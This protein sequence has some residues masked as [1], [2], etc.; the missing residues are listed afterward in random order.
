M[1]MRD[2][3]PPRGPRGP[4]GSGEDI[5]G[6]RYDR[7]PPPPPRYPP[8][9]GSAPS[10]RPDNPYRPFG[11]SASSRLPVPY[12]RAT[13]GTFNRL[14]ASGQ[15]YAADAAEDVEPHRRRL[16]FAIF[17][18]GNPGHLWRGS[19]ASTLGEGTLGVG[20][21]IW[22]AALTVSPLDVALGVL[23]LGLPFVLAGPLAARF[24]SSPEPGVPLRW[25]NRLRVLL[26]LGFIAMHFHT[27]LPVVY[28][29]L[30]AVSLC[31]RLHDALR[32]A[33]VRTCLARG[34]PEHVAN[35]LYI[36]SALAAVLG[37]L[38]ATFC[39]ILLGE[40]ILLIA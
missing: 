14:P 31:G 30:F 12:Q 4:R 25:L 27:I 8:S 21:L 40:R 17:H 13:L 38:V 9:R 5:P 15:A 26:A 39:Y 19:V 24:E 18:D 7:T 20:V 32:V 35:D 22:L 28:L 34:E 37:P 11:E 16:G 3:T 33:V 10:V 6:R 2:G 36:G 29:L 1:G 23:A